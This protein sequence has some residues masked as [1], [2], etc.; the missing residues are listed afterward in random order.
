RG[1]G[2]S[3]TKVSIPTHFPGCGVNALPGLPVRRQP[4]PRSPGKRSAARDEAALKPQPRRTPR[5]A[6]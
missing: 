6:A 5:V 3:R 2:R 1:P 4:W